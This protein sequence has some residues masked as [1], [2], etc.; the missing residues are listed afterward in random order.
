M[1][2]KHTIKQYVEN[3]YYHI[4]N[5]GIDRRE[6]FIDKQDCAFFLYCLK[7]YLSPQDILLK[8]QLLSPKMLYK[9]TQLN[10]NNELNLLSFALMPNHFHL[11]VKQHE[12]DSIAKLTRRVL[13]TYVQYFNKKYKRNGP[14][15]E[16]AYKA[17]LT[18][19]DA[20][21]LY[22]SC[23][24][25]RNPMKIKNAKFDFI[26]FSSYPYYLGEKHAAWINTDQILAH[27]R[28]AKNI[29]KQDVLSYQSFVE[30]TKE[31]PVEILK[32]LALDPDD[33]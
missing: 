23:Y 19:T 18:E 15:F 1:P 3:G 27:F 10:L 7:L 26:E 25:H 8:T 29:N 28:S 30:G 2:A 22:L 4:Y 6:I 12:K 32:T 16:S 14:L 5:R 31:D 11:Q 33:H 24:I 20:Q 17:I 21:H 13:T 9:I